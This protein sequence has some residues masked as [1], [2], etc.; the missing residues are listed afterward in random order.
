MISHVFKWWLFV[1][2]GFYLFGILTILP[3]PTDWQWARPQWLLLF[4][5]FCQLHQPKFFNVW[6]AWLIGLFLDSLLGTPLG[7]NA[8]IFS[9]ISYLGAYFRNKLL[10]KPF[11]LQMLKIMLLVGLAQGLTLWFHAMVGQKPY[12]WVYWSSTLSS[13][14]IWPIIGSFLHLISSLFKVSLFPTRSM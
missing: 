14:L 11:I 9:L 4:V 8:F 6:S 5:L 7:Q 1:I 2:V 13:T 3:M 10:Q 12:S